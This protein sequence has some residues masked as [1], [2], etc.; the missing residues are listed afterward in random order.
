MHQKGKEACLF[1]KWKTRGI[2]NPSLKLS[3][4]AL[5]KMIL[6]LGSF[7][8]RTYV[9]VSEWDMTWCIGTLCA[10]LCSHCY[11]SESRGSQGIVQMSIITVYCDGDSFSWQH[12]PLT[13]LVPHL[14]IRH[15]TSCKQLFSSKANAQKWKW[16]LISYNFYYTFKS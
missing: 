1:K 12:F 11:E 4:W 3:L 10:V 6:T 7:F 8:I 14:S 15:K 13:F 16:R 2:N 5:W 9:A